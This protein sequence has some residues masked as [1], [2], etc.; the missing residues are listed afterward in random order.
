MRPLAFPSLAPSYTHAPQKTMGTFFVFV[1]TPASSG[2]C[3]QITCD[4]R[5]VQRLP[6]NLSLARSCGIFGA[7]RRAR[8]QF[9]CMARRRGRAHVSRTHR[10]SSERLRLVN[11]PIS[12]LDAHELEIPSKPNAYSGGPTE[13]FLDQNAIGYCLDYIAVIRSSPRMSRF[14]AGTGTRVI[15]RRRF[16]SSSEKHDSPCRVPDRALETSRAVSYLGSYHNNRTKDFRQKVQTP[17]GTLARATGSFRR[18]D[19]CPD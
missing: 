17:S 5:P 11:P 15:R 1:E 3:C 10:F 13:L 12:I 6:G 19:I 7:V 14:L 2:K 4:D 8:W 18:L 9:C 16:V